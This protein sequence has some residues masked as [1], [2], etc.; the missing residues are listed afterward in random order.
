MLT[1][2]SNVCCLEWD[3]GSFDALLYCLSLEYEILYLS[4]SLAFGLN[5]SFSLDFDLYWLLSLNVDLYWLFSL[6]FDL[7]W[8]LKLG[9]YF[10]LSLED[11]LYPSLQKDFWLFPACIFLRRTLLSLYSGLLVS[12]GLY[13]CRQSENLFSWIVKPKQNTLPIH[14]IFPLG[15][16]NFERRNQHFC[17]NDSQASLFFRPDHIRIALPFKWVLQW[18]DCASSL[19]VLLI[20][21]QVT[22]LIVTQLPF[23]TV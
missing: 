14:S 22:Q 2:V 17:P 16:M 9:L 23:P 13:P 10:P 7:Y 6:I 11:G 19:L 21:R 4:L 12:F 1:L 15:V 5:G 8:S 18:P 3:L 20:D